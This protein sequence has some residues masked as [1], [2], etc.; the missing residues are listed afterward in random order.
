MAKTRLRV[1]MV[2]DKATISNLAG[3]GRKVRRRIASRSLRAG[4]KIILDEARNRASG[5]QDTGALRRSLTLVS[6]G[7]AGKGVFVATVGPRSNYKE[8]D[9]DGKI[10]HPA[11]Y[12]HV[13]E[14]GSRT[15]NIGRPFMTPTFHATSTAALRKV[16]RRLVAGIVK[17][18]PG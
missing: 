5:I 3:L 12:A 6:K 15:G 14:W 2:G 16:S 9:E 8:T 11:K 4:A 17:A 13:V 10:R 7:R 1:T 18:Q